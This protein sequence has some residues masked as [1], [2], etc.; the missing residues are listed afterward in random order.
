MDTA[1]PRDGSDP[2]W[3]AFAAR[4]PYFAVLTAPAFLRANLTP[5][6]RREFFASGEKYVHWLLHLINQHLVPEFAPMS[7]LEYGCGVGRL[8]IPFARRPGRVTAV[9]R[10]P[11]ML[12]LAREEAK[13]EGIA[14][15]DFLTP[16]QLFRDSR[17]FDLINCYGVFQRLEPGAGLA[18]LRQLVAILG[19]GGI[20]VFQFPYRA[21][22]STLVHLSRRLRSRVPLLNGMLNMTRGKA[23]ADP[24]IATHTYRLDDVFR[25]LD[26]EFSRRYRRPIAATHLLFEN[27]DGFAAFTACVEAPREHARPRAGTSRPDEPVDVRELI[28]QTGIADLNRR[29]EEYFSTL[30][31]RDHHLAKPFNNPEE[32]PSLLTG[33]A[34]MLQGLRPAAGMTVLEF[35]AGTGWLSRFMTQLGCRVIL[36]DVSTSALAV[37]QELYD[38]Q[39]IIGDRPRPGF[40]P[41][42]GHHIE[43]PD[44]SVDR[45]VSFHAFHHV[46]NPE[47]VLGEFGRVLRPG[48]IA[49]FV[50]PGPTHSHDAQSQFEM[51][52]YGVVEN[53]IDVHALWRTAQ[54]SG[55]SDLKLAVHHA[56][57]FLVSLGEFEDFLA[58]S[59]AGEPWVN[60]TRTYLR[61]VRTFFLFK[62]GIERLDSRS[63]G[64]LACRIEAV[65]RDPS[66]AG[67]QPIVIEATVHNAGS[68]VWL[69][70]EWEYGGV[71]LGAH[72]Y[73]ESGKLI[74]FDLVRQPL[75]EPPREVPPGDVVTCRVTIPPQPAGRYVVELDCVASKVIWFSQAG[76]EP[77]RLAFQITTDVSAP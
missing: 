10:S 15:I 8:A 52:N 57:L 36:L 76:S 4:E 50:E 27:Q 45:I 24:F 23:F 30:K 37:A 70:R 47:T 21:S 44:E 64:S 69:T 6:H 11:T 51:R 75:T 14:H 5:E 2:A 16:E 55:F 61:H 65:M 72:L 29:A 28:S 53:D 66:V 58:D 43:L 54:A 49:A 73:D 18:L 42:N 32:T 20:G 22:T 34:T 41:F 19:T 33:V 38:R 7:T 39:P 3:E 26:E 1:R 12:N 40:M 56:P 9:D 25:V 48:G 74:A 62:T 17:K 59:S 71:S 35:G 77:V 60:S 68:G 46:P 31:N 67:H 63:V 13:R